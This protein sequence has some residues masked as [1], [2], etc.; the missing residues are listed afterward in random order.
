MS[1]G[2]GLS[3]LLPPWHYAIPQVVYFQE[4][5]AFSGAIWRTAS[6]FP[7]LPPL[8][9][10]PLARTKLAGLPAGRVDVWRYASATSG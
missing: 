1:E 5:E 10:A 6:M 3:R 2:A 7:I 9:T 8:L 4:S